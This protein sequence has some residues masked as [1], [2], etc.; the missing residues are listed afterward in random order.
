VNEW[1]Q[2]I[3]VFVAWYRNGVW[4]S[5]TVFYY[6]QEEELRYRDVNFGETVLASNISAYRDQTCWHVLKVVA[7]FSRQ[8]YVRVLFDNYTYDLGGVAY[9]LSTFATV[10]HFHFGCGRRA[11]A[12]HNPVGYVD[13]IIVTQNEPAN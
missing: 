9:G 11:V 6:V 13:T 3:M 10:D 12:G 4:D 8:E 1:D 7:D 2:D 5:A